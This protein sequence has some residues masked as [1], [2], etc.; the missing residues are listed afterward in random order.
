MA[1]W[2]QNLTQMFA[3]A[4][5][6]SCSAP[7]FGQIPVNMDRRLQPQPIAV[8]SLPA[9][10]SP[11]TVTPAVQLPSNFSGIVVDRT[12]NFPV[13]FEPK[14]APVAKPTTTPLIDAAPLHPIT[15]ELNAPQVAAAESNQP[16]VQPN[17]A[18]LKPV[19]TPDPTEELL[20][21]CAVDVSTNAQGDRFKL[22]LAVPSNVTSVEVVNG[23]EPHQRFEIRLDEKSEAPQV[24]HPEIVVSAKPQMGTDEAQSMPVNVSKPTATVAANENLGAGKFKT[25]PF[26]NSDDVVRQIELTR[27][28][29]DVATGDRQVRG[30]GSIVDQPVYQQAPPA[31]M[32][33]PLMNFHEMVISNEQDAA[34]DLT[35]ANN[36]EIEPS[37]PVMMHARGTAD[38]AVMVRNTTNEETGRFQLRLSLP[39]GMQVT[40]LDRPAAYNAEFQTVTWELPA[41]KPGQSMTLRY[42]VK[43]ILDGRHTQAFEVGRGQS[44]GNL[45]TI[46]TSSTR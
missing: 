39:Q 5:M 42:R 28:N 14:P 30:I 32:N 43:S 19:V 33:S 22:H 37:G 40:V 8:Q 7:A 12:F 26:F 38:F 34:D 36:F 27:A 13:E 2:K 44:F 35:F 21:Q 15:P 45:T 20:K 3:A 46:S 31:S 11:Q 18:T 9:Q 29:I 25:N 41:M 1:T 17:A 16:L 10:P 24:D 23:D 4:V 6:I